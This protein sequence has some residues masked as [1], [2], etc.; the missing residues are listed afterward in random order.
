LRNSLAGRDILSLHRAVTAAAPGD[1]VNLG[2][3]SAA[4]HIADS[5]ST[6]FT[7]GP[8]LHFA[9]VR[10]T[11]ME[12]VSVPIQFAGIGGVGVTPATQMPLTAY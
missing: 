3:G 11:G 2:H 7:S 8:H 6:G 10:N 4:L 5:G 9:V 1:S 12:D